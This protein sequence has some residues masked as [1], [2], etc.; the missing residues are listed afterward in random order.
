[1]ARCGGK[2]VGQT[3]LLIGAALRAII[4]LGWAFGLTACTVVRVDGPARVTRVY[5]G[6]IR[7]EPDT[8]HSMLAYR[9][10]GFGI[11]PGRNG[12]TLGFAGETAVS[13]ASAE[14]CRIVLF[15]PDPETVGELAALLQPVIPEQQVCN[16]GGNE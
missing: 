11:V 10:R 15:D 5:P 14:E 16:I 12:L 6:I 3:F 7:V 2:E 4:A 1:M 13:I 9:S 8:G